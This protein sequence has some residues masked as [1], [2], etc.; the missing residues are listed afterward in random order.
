MGRLEDELVPIIDSI[1][2][3]N[4]EIE[5]AFE[6]DVSEKQQEKLNDKFLDIL[7]YDLERGRLDVSEHPFTIGNQF[8]ARITTRY[9]EEDISKSIMP[10]IHEFGHALY[11][12]GLP[13]KNTVFLQASQE[14]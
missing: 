14:I 6:S 13:K 9:S 8:D 4:V 3:S 12:L 11:E 1:R 5:N 10:T 7:G 2:Q